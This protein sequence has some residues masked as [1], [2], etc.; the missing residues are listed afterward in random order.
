[1]SSMYQGKRGRGCSVE[2]RSTGSRVPTRFQIEAGLNPSQNMSPVPKESFPTK[3]RYGVRRPRS[4]IPNERT[5]VT[6]SMSTN[7]DCMMVLDE[8][9]KHVIVLDDEKKDV[10][11]LD[12]NEKKDDEAKEE[13]KGEEKTEAKPLEGP[14]SGDGLGGLGRLEDWPWTWTYEEEW[15]WLGKG[16]GV[17]RYPHWETMTGVSGLGN[18]EDSDDDNDP[19]GFDDIWQLRKIKEIPKP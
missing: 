9:K 15:M 2:Q 3:R 19:W 14:G 12:D 7:A 1:M 17:G 10:I 16:S 18:L 4:V 8:R 13:I 6:R 11:V 5:I